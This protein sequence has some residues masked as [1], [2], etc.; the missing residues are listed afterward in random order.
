MESLR[1]QIS[2]LRENAVHTVAVEQALADPGLPDERIPA[3]ME[4][5]EQIDSELWSDDFD[6]ETD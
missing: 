4:T 5:V 1:E 2:H 3:I 6:W